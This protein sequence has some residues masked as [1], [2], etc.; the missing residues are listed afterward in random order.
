[1]IQNKREERQELSKEILIKNH[2]RPQRST[3]T[4]I[5]IKYYFHITFSRK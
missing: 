3:E 4:I 5:F 2:E 1:M